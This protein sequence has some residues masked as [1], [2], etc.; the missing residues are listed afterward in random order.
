[1]KF[2]VEGHNYRS[3]FWAN[4]VDDLIEQLDDNEVPC[5]V[6]NCFTNHSFKLTK[7]MLF[8]VKK[9]GE[10]FC[11]RLPGLRRCSFE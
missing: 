11:K 7:K 6:T 10:T 9:N 3:E 8:G 2:L 5:T 4:S 1:M